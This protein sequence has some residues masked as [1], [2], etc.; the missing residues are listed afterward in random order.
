MATFDSQRVSGT[1]LRSR[2]EAL[3]TL[4]SDP[5]DSEDERVRK[6]LL[7]TAVLILLPLTA[8]WGIIYWIVGAPI[9][10]AIPWA[11]TVLSVISVVT[12]G[13]TRRYPWFA[14]SQFSF[15]SILP[16]VL[17]WVLGGFVGGSAVALWAALG[18]L[19]ALILGHQRLAPALLA[20]YVVLLLVSASLP[21]APF[22]EPMPGALVAAFFVLNL[23]AVT[24]VAFLL[25]RTFAGGRESSLHAL[26]G[27]VHR[28]L[29][30]DIAAAVLTNPHR[31]EL[32]GEIAD[33]SVLFADLGGYTTFAE[34]RNP[35]E[36]VALLN[37]YFAVAVPCIL[38]EGG[39]PIQMPGDAV[40]A[41]FGA[42]RPL[43]DHAVR[44]CR[45]ALGIAAIEPVVEGAPRFHVGVNS[46]PALV[47]NIGSEEFRNFTA[48]GDTTNLAARLEQ[49]A[50]PGQIAV[51]PA[52]AAAVRGLLQ[53][54]PL[55]SV[56]VK[57]KLS[58][59]EVCEL[60]PAT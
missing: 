60:L 59:I 52:T 48:I 12:F 26:R 13:L 20:G 8:G 44:A 15:Y 50:E 39:T 45:A 53:L 30:A 28:Y 24:V 37:R 2:L 4:G 3:L 34:R 42:P 17:M 49:L 14:L 36:V 7:L 38:A 23:T 21:T 43:P 27:I 58:P 33:L 6:I 25:L 46:G 11:Y 18:P 35:D 16:F 47:G 41:I 54:R 32:G 5:Q 10:A 57:G 29:S 51:G 22:V 9:A 31:Q 40:M 56:Q 55:G 19:V 1:S